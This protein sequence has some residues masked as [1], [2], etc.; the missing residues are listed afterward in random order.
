MSTS[1]KFRNQI[2]RGLSKILEA[3]HM[4][5]PK[6]GKKKRVSIMLTDEILQNERS[7]NYYSEH[8]IKQETR[9]AIDIISNTDSIS[10]TSNSYEMIE[11]GFTPYEIEAQKMS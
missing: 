10:K 7:E 5:N 6:Y 1:D 4:V 11:Y 2:T 9:D 3:K 8:F